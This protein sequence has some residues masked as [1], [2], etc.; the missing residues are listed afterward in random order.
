[1]SKVERPV[2]EFR[3]LS[4]VFKG[5]V[6]RYADGKWIDDDGEYDIAFI[7]QCW[8]PVCLYVEHSYQRNIVAGW[9]TSHWSCR[10]NRH[11]NANPWHY[12]LRE[13][14]TEWGGDWGRE[15]HLN[16]RAGSS[17]MD[18]MRSE[19]SC[20]NGWHVDL[21]DP[22]DAHIAAGLVRDRDTKEIFTFPKRLVCMYCGD[23]F[24][25]EKEIDHA[26]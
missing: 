20:S 4:D 22:T 21:K 23:E 8:A 19:N 17:G 3:P 18:K 26:K 12:V 1:M 25:H 11:P 16:Y 10:N 24:S 7:G 6:R 14:E 2:Y 15:R 9:L 13:G 5:P